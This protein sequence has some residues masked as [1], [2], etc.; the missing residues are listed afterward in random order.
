MPEVL[1]SKRAKDICEDAGRCGGRYLNTICSL[2]VLMVL[3]CLGAYFEADATMFRA[4]V[5][6]DATLQMTLDLKRASV[7][8]ATV[9]DTTGASSTQCCRHFQQA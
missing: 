6:F 8:A 7:P 9:A 4:S 5:D 1:N 2:F 3:A